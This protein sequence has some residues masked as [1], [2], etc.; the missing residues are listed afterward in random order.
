MLNVPIHGIIVSYDA[1][2][3]SILLQRRDQVQIDALAAAYA[4]SNGDA[5]FWF[6]RFDWNNITLADK[7]L[8]KTL[9]R[10]SR[11]LLGR[12]VICKVIKD[13]K[14]R[15]TWLSVDFDQP[16]VLLPE[17]RTNPAPQGGGGKRSPSRNFR[18]APKHNNI[19]RPWGGMQY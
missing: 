5:G 16:C 15:T 9:P 19:G 17:R 4:K 7:E 18:S 14:W 3:G 12:R 10:K 13:P 11:K 2:R 8:H 6:A 1:G